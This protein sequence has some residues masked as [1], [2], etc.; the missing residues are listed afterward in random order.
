MRVK[1]LGALT[2]GGETFFRGVINSFTSPIEIRFLKA[3]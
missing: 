3:L 2:A 1:L